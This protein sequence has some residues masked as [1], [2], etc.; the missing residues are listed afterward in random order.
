M[1]QL[2]PRGFMAAPRFLRLGCLFNL[3]SFGRAV[4]ESLKMQ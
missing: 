1:M 3:V 2:D 4:C